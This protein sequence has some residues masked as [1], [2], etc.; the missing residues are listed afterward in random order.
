MIPPS[1]HGVILDDF[2]Y[3]KA[4]RGEQVSI[5]TTPNGACCRG[6]IV[7]IHSIPAS[8]EPR[9]VKTYAGV[10]CATSAGPS[11]TLLSPEVASSTINLFGL[12]KLSLKLGKRMNELTFFFAEKWRLKCHLDQPNESLNIRSARIYSAYAMCLTVFKP[13][14]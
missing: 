3:G 1:S 9:R 13:M 4:M 12:Y 5:S 14:S 2:G 11:R 10:G 7:D 6:R 8:C